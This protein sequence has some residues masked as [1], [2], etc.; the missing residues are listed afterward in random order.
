MF[1]MIPF[2]VALLVPLLSTAS[3]SFATE[4]PKQTLMK[5]EVREPEA[6]TGFY[7]KEAVLGKEYM[8]ASANPYASKAGFAM[9]EAGGSAVDAAIAVQLVLTLVEPQSSGIGGGAFMLHWHNEDK[10]LT[11]LDGRETAPKSATS[12]LF[13][14]ANGKPL[15]WRDAV[16]GGRSV[17]VPGLLA[18]LKKAHDQLE[19]YHGTHYLN[20]RLSWLSMALLFRLD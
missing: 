6:A 8:V 14:K 1:R 2:S 18:S 9:L 19:N 3:L 15:S 20:R 11:T 13:L 17:G 12:D 7:A 10:K 4:A 16:V 5:R